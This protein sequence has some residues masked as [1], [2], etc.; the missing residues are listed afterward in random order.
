MLGVIFILYLILCANRIAPDGTPRF[1][2][3][4]PGLFC[5]PMTHKRDA[6]LKKMIAISIHFSLSN[7]HVNLNKR[8]QTV[9]IAIS[10]VMKPFIGQL[11]TAHKMIAHQENMSVY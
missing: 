1:A 11:E 8:N 2:A 4:H 5:L 9:N 6:R 3:S 10:H 7:I